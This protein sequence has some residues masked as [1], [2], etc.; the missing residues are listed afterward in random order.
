MRLHYDPETDSLY[1]KLVD[2][3]GADSDE[4]A[5][6]VVADFDAD[7]RLVGLDVEH[8]SE[9]FDLTEVELNGVPAR[10]LARAQTRAG[11]G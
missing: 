2:R 10:V 1:I 8:A 9:V 11:S 5:P 7:G 3:P 6:G 4:I